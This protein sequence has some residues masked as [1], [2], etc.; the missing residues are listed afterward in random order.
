MKGQ[1]SNLERNRQTEVKKMCDRGD[2]Y[3]KEE[4][5][6]AESMKYM[7]DAVSRWSTTAM[8]TIVGRFEIDATTNEAVWRVQSS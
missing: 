8:A 4:E 2:E 5:P 6:V 7:N 3:D 1:I